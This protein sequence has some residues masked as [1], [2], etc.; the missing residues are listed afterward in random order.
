MPEPARG[1]GEYHPSTMS[2]GVVITGLGTV[3]GFGLGADALWDGLLSGRSSL[4][5]V[6]RFDASGFPTRLAAEVKG[7]AAKDHV[8]KYYRKAV[9]VMARDIELAV[10]AAKSAVLDAGLVTRAT[11]TEK[12]GAAPE[13][14]DTGLTYAP[15]RMGCQ[16][17]AGLIATETD[18]LAAALATARPRPPGSAGAGGS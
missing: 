6:T 13:G 3:S 18:E 8:P 5:P 1:R 10:G 15:S 2:R 14:L 9:K 17:G 7:F 4:G 11:I 12:N 16:I